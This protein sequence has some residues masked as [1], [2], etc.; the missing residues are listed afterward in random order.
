MRLRPL[1]TLLAII[2]LGLCCGVTAAAARGRPRPKVAAHQ[3]FVAEHG[4]GRQGGSSCGAAKSLSWFED[5][6]QWGPGTRMAPGS[7]VELCGTI[8]SPVVIRGSG[9][10]GKPITINFL[11]GAKISLPACPPS[12]AGCLSTDQHDYITINGGRDGIVESTA[13]GTDL[14]MHVQNVLGIWAL[15]CNGCVIENLTIRDMYIHTS[16]SDTQAGGDGVIFSGQNVTVRNNTLHD[17]HWALVG[18][19]HTGDGNIRIVGN[20]IYRVDHGFAST[21]AGG[22]RVGRLYFNGNDLHDYANWDT[23]SAAY[24]HDGVHCYSYDGGAAHYAGIYI[25]DNRF[26]GAPGIDMTSQI[27]IEGGADG[28]PC[29]DPATPIYIFNNVLAASALINNGLLYTAAGQVRI[30]NNTLIGHSGVC[31]SARGGTVDEVFQNNVVMGCDGLMYSPDPSVFAQGSPDYNLYADGGL[32]AFICTNHYDPFR[33][34][35][36]W[37]ACMGADRHSRTAANPRLSATGV[38]ARRSPAAHSGTN[39]SSLCSGPL[40]QLCTTL[41]GHRRPTRGSW[42]VGAY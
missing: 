26:G 4:S 7:T 24:H 6:A 27:F 31:V 36:R 22:V 34:F 2:G 20:H 41:G 19:W 14:P 37:R 15:N 39:L 33:A 12:G 5:P 9:L 40:T 28:T 16:R 11:P 17:D 32:N 13:N 23:F 1:L 18:E 42:P 25:Y 38:P 10:P 8:S 21:A 30:Y 29:A 3:V 35:S